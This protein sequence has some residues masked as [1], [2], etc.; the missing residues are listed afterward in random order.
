MEAYLSLF[1]ALSNDI[2]W[3]I[4]EFLRSGPFCV[5]ALAHRLRVSQPAVSQHLKL[6]EQAGLVQGEKMG[7]QVH[8]ALIPDRLRECITAIEGLIPAEGEEGNAICREHEDCDC[9][10]GKDPEGCS[11]E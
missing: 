2:R 9:R 10:N 1:K 8:Y 3:Q 5:T 6:L 11:P 4:L 7:L